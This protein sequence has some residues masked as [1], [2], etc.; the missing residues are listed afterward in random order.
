MLLFMSNGKNP[1]S[2]IKKEQNMTFIMFCTQK[3]L[4]MGAEQLDDRGVF[5]E[6]T[7]PGGLPF[8]SKR[9][10]LDMPISRV[11]VI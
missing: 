6:K 1:H 9:Y 2:V 7:T 11:F 4:M 8:K 5:E 10:G 3:Q